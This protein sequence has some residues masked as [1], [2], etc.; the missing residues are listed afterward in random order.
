[1]SVYLALSQDVKNNPSH[2]E[3]IYQVALEDKVKFQTFIVEPNEIIT[4]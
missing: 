3:L 4:N 1:M 2:S